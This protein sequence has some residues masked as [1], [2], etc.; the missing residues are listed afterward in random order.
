MFASPATKKIDIPGVVHLI[1]RAGVGRV[2]IEE[3]DVEDERLTLVSAEKV[4][5]LGLQELRLGQLDR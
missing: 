5:G 1:E 3:V 4:G 2:R